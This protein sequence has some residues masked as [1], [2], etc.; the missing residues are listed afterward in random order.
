MC[1]PLRVGRFPGASGRYPGS[2]EFT[3]LGGGV[4]SVCENRWFCIISGHAFS[5]RP[6]AVVYDPRPLGPNFLGPTAAKEAAEKRP[7][8]AEGVGARFAAGLKAP[9]FWSATTLFPQPLKPT[10]GEG[11]SR[12][13][14]KSCPDTVY[15]TDAIKTRIKALRWSMSSKSSQRLEA[16]LSNLQLELKT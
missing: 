9:P 1:D 13:D 12:H 6:N 4:K 10:E 8:I 15:S 14:W 7:Q 11:R 16:Q 2:G 5:V 3:S